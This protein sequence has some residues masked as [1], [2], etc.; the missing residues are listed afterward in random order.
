MKVFLTIIL[1]LWA[2]FYYIHSINAM[3]KEDN[4]KNKSLPLKAVVI[5]FAIE[6]CFSLLSVC[7]GGIAGLVIS[8]ILIAALGIFQ[9]TLDD[10]HQFKGVVALSVPLAYA[11]ARSKAGNFDTLKLFTNGL[12]IFKS[13]LLTFVLAV[14]F[15]AIC[16]FIRWLIV[17]KKF[18]G[19]SRWIRGKNTN[20]E[21][22]EEDD[23]DDEFE[24]PS[25]LTPQLITTVVVVIAAAVAVTIILI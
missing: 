14:A 5:V 13:L 16:G 21:D 18:S 20:D 23:D 17:E 25:W 1:A 12:S 3:R 4:K 7:L 11:A 6:A 8:V 19:L 22:E 9:F 15:V 24:R 10:A 2:T